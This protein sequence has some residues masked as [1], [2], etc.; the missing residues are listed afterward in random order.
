[1]KEVNFKLIKIA[2]RLI[3][4]KPIHHFKNVSYFYHYIGVNLCKGE[5]ISRFL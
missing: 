4:F 2:R 5:L 3:L 1:M